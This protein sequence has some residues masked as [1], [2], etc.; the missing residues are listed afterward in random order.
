MLLANNRSPQP[1]AEMKRVLIVDDMREMH[2]TVR[3]ILRAVGVGEVLGAT[4]IGQARDELVTAQAIQQ[5]FDLVFIDQI[6]PGGSGLQ[7]IWEI[8]EKGEELID[9][10]HTGV[11]V[12]SG[13]N[14]QAFHQAA[15]EAGVVAVLQ[16]PFSANQIVECGTRWM[17][18]RE[19]RSSDRRL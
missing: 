18:S 8:E 11:F 5:P 10:D 7:L 19:R 1:L 15:L 3:R 17:I 6:M 4:N 9:L 2:S 13:V 12:L 16:K 14:D